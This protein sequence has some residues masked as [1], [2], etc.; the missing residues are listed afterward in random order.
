MALVQ[1]I[2]TAQQAR[3]VMATSSLAAQKAGRSWRNPTR[4]H[5]KHRRRRRSLAGGVTGKGR[6]MQSGRGGV[7]FG[8]GGAIRVEALRVTS[9]QPLHEP[10]AGQILLV[11]FGR[12]GGCHVLEILAHSTSTAGLNFKEYPGQDNAVVVFFLFVRQD[13]GW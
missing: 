7:V 1:F 6:R 8:G 10:V 11:S 5:D 2:P 9:V 13:G 4:W 3:P 12:F